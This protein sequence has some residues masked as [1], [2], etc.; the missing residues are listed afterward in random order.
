V[1][2]EET[3]LSL[4]DDGR[5][6]AHLSHEVHEYGPIL[7]HYDKHNNDPAY[8]RH[9]MKCKFC[10]LHPKHHFSC[11]VGMGKSTCKISWEGQKKEKVISAASHMLGKAIR[12]LSFVT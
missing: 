12:A 8:R 4:V 9:P 2:G 10:T 5:R 6:A 1:N 3:P 7:Y 11:S